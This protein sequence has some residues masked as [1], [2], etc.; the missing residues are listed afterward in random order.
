LKENKTISTLLDIGTGSGCIAIALKKNRPEAD[1]SALDVSEEALN[2]ALK[3]AE[4]NAVSINFFNIDILKRGSLAPEIKTNFD[5][6]VSNPPYI[7]LSEKNSMS[8]N[9]VDYEPHLALFVEENDEIVFY[10]KII[11]LCNTSLKPGG[12][13]YFELNPLTSDL[14]NSYAKESKQF[15]STELIKDMS[16]AIRFF[17]AIKN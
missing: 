9:V 13:L 11:D 8:Q 5:V 17:K 12:E 7:R 14:V 3:N 1:T 6:I 4:M 15:K 10:R 16:G 2:V